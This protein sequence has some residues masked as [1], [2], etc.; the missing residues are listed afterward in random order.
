MCV[1][2]PLRKPFWTFWRCDHN[3]AR[4]DLSWRGVSCIP[5]FIHVSTFVWRASKRTH[6][7]W[8]RL[9]PRAYDEI[10]KTFQYIS[11]ICTW[12]NRT[13]A[14]IQDNKNNLEPC[15]VFQQ[16]SQCLIEPTVLKPF[17]FMIRTLS[18]E[19][20]TY[21]RRTWCLF[22]R[23]GCCCTGW[24]SPPVD[25]SCSSS[26]WPLMESWWRT[27]ILRAAPPGRLCS[28]AYRD[29]NNR[30]MDFKVL[31]EDKKKQQ[32]T[33]GLKPVYYLTKCSASS[34]RISSGQSLTLSSKMDMISSWVIKRAAVCLL[35]S[36]QR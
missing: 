13:A 11:S 20:R 32:K 7:V 5:A 14:V 2:K 8:S 24:W 4:F 18:V 36:W 17:W 30:R 29:M 22:Q 21:R 9:L 15:S 35:R 19:S 31:A 1:F 25:P 23:V 34:E 26:S 28:E 6:T 10:D 3:I 16:H 27:W 33:F 12:L